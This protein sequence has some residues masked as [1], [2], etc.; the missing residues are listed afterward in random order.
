MLKNLQCFLVSQILLAVYSRALR[1]KHSKVEKTFYEGNSYNILSPC[2]VNYAI[3]NVHVQDWKSCN[4]T[5]ANNM[6]HWLCVCVCVYPLVEFDWA[7]KWLTGRNMLRAKRYSCFAQQR[8]ML[9]LSPCAILK[10]ITAKG[11][12]RDGKR[13]ERTGQIFLHQQS[14]WSATKGCNCNTYRPRVER[15]VDIVD[16]VIDVIAVAE[17]IA[18]VGAGVV[19]ARVLIRVLAVVVVLVMLVQHHRG[20]HVGVL[21]ARIRARPRSLRRSCFARK[22]PSSLLVSSHDSESKIRCST[23]RAETN[24]RAFDSRREYQ[25]I[26]RLMDGWMDESLPEPSKARGRSGNSSR[27][28]LVSRL[29]SLADLDYF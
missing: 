12:S 18:G 20:E 4:V 27:W 19:V 21:R 10:W 23:R 26:V 9:F 24:R 28:F 13:E 16:V 15:L 2:R 11:N 22:A 3:F 14:A 17:V 6:A 7:F 25:A 1:E 29:R 8:E 5:S